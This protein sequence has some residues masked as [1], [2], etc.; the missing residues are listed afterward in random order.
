MNASD[1]LPRKPLPTDTN[2]VSEDTKHLINNIISDAVALSVSFDEIK[3]E[4]L[5]DLD[6][7]SIIQSVSTNF[8]NKNILPIFYRVR[9]EFTVKDSI[10]LKSNRLVIPELL[11]KRILDIA[12]QY[13]LGEK[14]RWPG[15]D[16]DVEDLIQSCH[17]LYNNITLY[18]NNSNIS[19][20][21]APIDIIPE[22][23]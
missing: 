21:V 3:N 18:N 8:W 5:S 17:S 12:H 16:Q 9:N 11:R 6:L 14:V 4:T 2:P 1:V 15:L 23:C 10:L 22:N 19:V 20:L 7:C 13:H